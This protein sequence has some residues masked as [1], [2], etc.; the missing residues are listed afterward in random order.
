MNQQIEVNEDY[1]MLELGAALVA[2]PLV[3]VPTLLV[4]LAHIPIPLLFAHWTS[5][6]KIILF[7]NK[8]NIY[9]FY[10]EQNYKY[11][12]YIFFP[13]PDTG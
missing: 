10:T 3:L 4:P 6:H 1:V 2:P 12:F 13:S 11:Y 5:V 9:L 7:S 8:M